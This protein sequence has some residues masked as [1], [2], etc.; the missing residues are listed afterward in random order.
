MSNETDIIKATITSITQAT[1]RIKVFRLDYENRDFTFKPGQWIDLYAP[2]EGKNIGG[3]TITSS[4]FE[5]GQI[6]LAIRESSTHPVTQ[7]LHN[8]VTPGSTVM[9]TEGQGKFFITEELL[10]SPLT[11]IA[12]GIGLTPLISMFRSMDK[13]KTPLKIF[14]SVS[15]DEDILFKDELAPY[16]VFT[17]TKSHTANW[18]GETKRI[19]LEMLKKYKTD[20]FSD[21]FICGPRPMIDGIVSQLV[22]AGVDK[23]KIHYEKWW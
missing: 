4:V 2:V 23:N 6:E 15:S 22:Q 12:G 9:I 20:F 3:Y 5:K 11:F 18:E 7:Y 19:D 10:K 13:T 8:D 16:T 1:K 17:A 21:F 14:Y